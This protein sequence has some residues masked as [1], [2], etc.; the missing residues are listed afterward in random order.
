[1]KKLFILL[2]FTCMISQNMHVSASEE[3]IL[4]DAIVE[5][6]NTYGEK[7]NICP[8]L[9]EALIEKESAGDPK[10]KRGDCLGLMQISE[11]YHKERA[12]ALGCPDFYDINQNIQ[13]GADILS[14]LFEKHE[15]VYLVLMCYNAGEAK[16]LKLYE[17]GL[18]SRY[19]V[20]ICKRA[21][22][23]ERFHGK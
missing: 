9:L 20:D 16:A 6:C 12:I 19:T 11:T 22:E 10:A 17:Q 4:S 3:T 13:V 18:F 7:Y 21:E 23:L 1:M 14:E 5:A 8:E 15:D 2:F